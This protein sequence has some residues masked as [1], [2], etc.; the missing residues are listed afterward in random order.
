MEINKNKMPTCIRRTCGRLGS[1][2]QNQ[3]FVLIYILFLVSW[4]AGWLLVVG[5]CRPCA[6]IRGSA[7]DQ[8]TVS[9]MPHSMLASQEWPVPTILHLTGFEP[10]TYSS[11]PG[12][13]STVPRLHKKKDI[14]SVLITICPISLPQNMLLFV[15]GLPQNLPGPA[16]VFFNLGVSQSRYFNGLKIVLFFFNQVKI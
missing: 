4:L 14:S 3:V 15:H 12:V 16:A 2:F 13:L 10:P 8:S 9:N 11:G 1:S 7:G 5:C 6:H